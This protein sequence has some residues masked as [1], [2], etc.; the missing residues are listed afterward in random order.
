MLKVEASRMIKEAGRCDRLADKAGNPIVARSLREL[1]EWY[2]AK[3]DDL[4]SPAAG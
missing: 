4:L 2:R 1:A 3:A